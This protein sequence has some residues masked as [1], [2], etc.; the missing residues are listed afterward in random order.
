ML[1]RWLAPLV[2]AATIVA[3]AS[4]SSSVSSVTNLAREARWAALIALMLAGVF[5][6][7][8][9]ARTVGDLRAFRW[10]FIP[11]AALGVLA[12]LST[13]WSLAPMLTF[14]RAGS[15]VILIVGAA[16]I[17][18]SVAGDR[19]ATERLL[20]GAVLGVGIVALIGVGMLVAGSTSASVAETSQT[21]WRYQG[22]GM[23][24]NTISMLAAVALPPAALF[25]FGAQPRLRHGLAGIG[26]LALYF[27]VIASE[28]R[29]ALLASLV[30]MI[31]V[32]WFGVPGALRKSSVLTLVLI[33]FVGGHVFRLSNPVSVQPPQREAVLPDIDPVIVDTGGSLVSF[34]L[35]R[36]DIGVRREDE[37]GNPVFGDELSTAGSG[38]IAAWKGALD[39]IRGRPVLGF[40]FGTESKAFVDRWYYFQGANPENAY[41]GLLLQLG[42][43]GLLLFVATGVALLVIALRALS[44]PHEL[45]PV[46]AALLG[47]VC[48]GA[49]LMA[50]QS[51]I[52]SVG[53]VATVTVW[54]A[55]F[56]LATTSWHVIREP[57]RIASGS[58]STRLSR[59]ARGS[60]AL[61]GR[62]GLGL[63]AA[64]LVLIG[65]PLLGRWEADR[66]VSGQLR[67]LRATYEAAG[68]RVDSPLLTAYRAG[69]P[70]CFFYA[71]GVQPFALRLCF[72]DEGRLVESAD[73][74]GGSPRYSTIAETPGRATITVAAAR[75]D[76]LLAALAGK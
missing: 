68:G 32:T 34:P 71:V 55:G 72:D 67:E 15:L 40:G 76:S 50:V 58:A 57:G 4:G 23:N 26:V 51:Y 33:A 56:A 31:V 24:P 43:A 7:Q 25:A 17:A 28:S 11:P 54:I 10:I 16:G 6:G 48:A 29:G 47:V 49:L 38:R 59:V 39:V 46:I 22:Y 61:G 5:L 60:S 45:R 37:I 13:T 12:S 9:R 63:L 18:Y 21:A 27:T 8:A 69:H 70:R 2:L 74:R 20:A 53:N 52:Y 62:Y 41:L 36:G 64:T 44:R 30:G 35:F 3:F 66:E 65:L 73:R 19:A 14:E 75:I 1:R 42:F